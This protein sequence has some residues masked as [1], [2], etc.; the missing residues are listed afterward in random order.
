MSSSDTFKSVEYQREFEL[1]AFGHSPVSYEISLMHTW[2]SRHGDKYHALPHENVD[3]S[4]RKM[5]D[6]YENHLSGNLF[7]SPDYAHH[8]KDQEDKDAF[9]M[10]AFSEKGVEYGSSGLA[11][12]QIG[13]LVRLY[14]SR[15]SGQKDASSHEAN[16]ECPGGYFCGKDCTSKEEAKE[17]RKQERKARKDRQR[18]TGSNDREVQSQAKKGEEVM[19]LLGTYAKYVE[20]DN[21]AE[22][23]AFEAAMVDRLKTDGYKM[24]DLLYELFVCQKRVAI[25]QGEFEAMKNLMRSL[26]EDYRHDEDEDDDE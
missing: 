9:D 26:Q 3:A 8:F 21:K 14:R 16:E 23:A 15:I 18:G 13:G 2:N 5:V 6:H 1:W 17:R 20:T 4:I 12:K 10:W 19:D 25:L 22:R 24:S 11:K 7:C